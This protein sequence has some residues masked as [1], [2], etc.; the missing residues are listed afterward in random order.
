MLWTTANAW[1]NN[2]VVGGIGGWRLPTMM[3]TAAPGCDWTYAGGT[4]CG[5]N[6]QTASS[7]MAHLFY[8]T[9]GNKSWC[10]PAT[11]TVAVCSGPQGGGGLTNT[12]GFQNVQSYVYWSGLLY[13]PNPSLAWYFL[14]FYGTQ[15]YYG[16][17][18]GLYALAVRPGDVAAVPEPQVAALMLIGLTGLALALR[19]R[20]R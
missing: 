16:K 2:L 11:S 10:D 8:V 3:D 18:G 7:E 12:G 20:P 9:L 15:T 14:T 13:A 19:R 17:S 4:D 5:A 1:A 6:V